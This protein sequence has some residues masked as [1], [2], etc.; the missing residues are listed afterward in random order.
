MH[1]RGHPRQIQFGHHRAVRQ[2]VLFDVSDAVVRIG[3]V[4]LDQNPVAFAAK[5]LYPAIGAHTRPSLCAA[6][7]LAVRRGIHG[8]G[9][10]G[11]KGDEGRRERP[12]GKLR[13][14]GGV[15]PV[16]VIFGQRNTKRQHQGKQHNQEFFHDPAPFFNQTWGE[17]WAYPLGCRRDAAWRCRGYGSWPSEGPFC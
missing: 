16:F 6:K 9:V 3:D 14:I 5:H 12:A 10:I 1:D 17:G 11:G 13:R 7:A 15:H 4:V 8:I 2:G